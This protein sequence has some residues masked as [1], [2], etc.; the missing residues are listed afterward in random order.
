MYIFVRFA[1]ILL[2]IVGI[3]LLLGGPALIVYSFAQS[4]MLIG[5]INQ[6]LLPGT[7]IRIEV[8]KGFEFVGSL[9]GTLLFFLGLFLAAFGQFMLVF[10]DI[11]NQTRET[12][13]L[14]RQLASRRPAPAVRPQTEEEPYVVLP[15]SQAQTAQSRITQARV[16]QVHASQPEINEYDFPPEGFEPL[17]GQEPQSART[18]YP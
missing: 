14:L 18:T 2:L 10:V 4:D 11:A 7:N 8:G 13:L 6:N 15:P 17:P 1:A 5:F 3:V 9:I 12:N 16:T